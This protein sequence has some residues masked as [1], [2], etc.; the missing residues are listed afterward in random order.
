MCIIEGEVKFIKLCRADAGISLFFSSFFFSSFL[1]FFRAAKWRIPRFPRGFQQVVDGDG[2]RWWV[3]NVA[4]HQRVVTI[5]RSSSKSGLSEIT[6]RKPSVCGKRGTLREYSPSSELC[7]EYIYTPRAQRG[8]LP[9]AGVPGAASQSSAWPALLVLRDQQRH[10]KGLLRVVG[11]LLVLCD[12]LRWMGSPRPCAYGPVGHWWGK[13]RRPWQ[14]WKD[15]GKRPCPSLL[16]RS[17]SSWA[18]QPAFCSPCNPTLNRPSPSRALP[19]AGWDVTAKLHRGN[20]SL[21]CTLR[22]PRLLQ[23]AHPILPHQIYITIT[24]PPSGLTAVAYFC[25]SSNR[26]S[27]CPLFPCGPRPAPAPRSLPPL[28]PSLRANSGRLAHVQRIYISVHLLSS[29]QIYCVI[30]GE[31]GWGQGIDTASRWLALGATH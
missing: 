30:A 7:D 4:I 21:D 13:G 17:R 2:D 29:P 5:L 25:V 14:S 19:D 12:R 23:P 20:Q 22:N 8:C 18:M 9:P 31:G 3:C 10:S 15:T 28:R 27:S 24:A 1:S 6:I 11:Q 16:S 26:A